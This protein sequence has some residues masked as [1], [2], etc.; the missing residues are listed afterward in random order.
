MSIEAGV[1]LDLKG[2]PLYW[3]APPNRSG[4]AI[5]D[6]RDLWEVIWEHRKNLLGFAHSHPGSG[7]TGPS[8]EDITTF[9]DIE[10]GLGRRLLWPILTSDSYCLVKWAGPELVRD[11]LHYWPVQAPAVR[12]PDPEWMTELRR[13]SRY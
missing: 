5:P 6:S 12:L 4:G 8:Y 2:N 13:L 1:L 10:Q 3:H 11:R 9:A 7:P